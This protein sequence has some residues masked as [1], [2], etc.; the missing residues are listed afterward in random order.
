MHFSLHAVPIRWAI[1]VA[2]WIVISLILII[3][4]RVAIRLAR[5][6][7]ERTKTELDDKIVQMIHS[8]QPFVL[9]AVGLALATPLAPIHVGHVVRY[10]V[11]LAVGM[12]LLI[13]SS[14]IIGPV[15]AHFLFRNSAEEN[16]TARNALDILV[17]V[18]LWVVIALLILENLGVKIGT[19]IAGLG[20]G[21]IAIGLALQNVASDLFASLSIMLDK[22]FQVGD[23]ILL[24]T[25][26]GTV[27]RVGIKSTRLRAL[28]GE[29]LIL[30][31]TDLTVGSIHNYRNMDERRIV[32][33]IG[34][35]YDTPSD[36]VKDIPALL[37]GIIESK[38]STRF[39][40]AHFQGFGPSSLDFQI[41]Y[42]V[43]SRDYYLFMDLQQ[44]IN[45][46]ILEEF[47]QR[48]IAFA[49]PT[50]T[51]IMDSASSQTLPPQSHG[52]SSPPVSSP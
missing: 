40:R 25:F 10:I 18:T 43:L 11:V 15:A 27:E 4:K 3:A 31:N 42:Y 21:G 51:I 41:V 48:G 50:Q 8:I 6:W 30:P 7:A 35:T 26:S 34:V 47:N 46:E 29:E 5:P 33:Q 44:S 52:G 22:P 23:Y 13:T 28:T 17:K 16:Q 1:A 2:S 14:Q 20:V 39:D 12:Q 49:F 38:A 24:N 32:F 37:K 19:L 9:W 36:V 45:L